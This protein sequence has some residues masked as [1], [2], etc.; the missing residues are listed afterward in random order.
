MSSA[1]DDA[2]ATT[3]PTKP[4]VGKSPGVTIIPATQRP[5][6]TWR[7]EVRVKAGYVPPDEVPRYRAPHARMN[8]R[9]VNS[10]GP[11]EPKQPR[12]AAPAQVKP[13][14]ATTATTST[15]Q[16]SS[17]STTKAEISKLTEQL[18]KVHISKP[19]IGDQHATETKL[20]A[21]KKKI[22]QAEELK[23]RV[24]RKEATPNADQQ[25]KLNR[26]PQLK[27]EL[28]RLDAKNSASN[29]TL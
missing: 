22:R 20:K 29:P 6:G 17:P 13:P 5:D 25:E 21:L 2:A 4:A 14:A 18:D 3:A 9:N 27:E 16:H 8:E 10:P 7:P 26:L 28:A 23:E 24:D 19:G 1:W 12:P 15:T 11:V